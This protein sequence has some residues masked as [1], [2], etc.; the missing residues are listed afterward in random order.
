MF[1]R[2]KR[3][4]KPK[5][6]LPGPSCHLSRATESP[7]KLD[8]KDA[9]PQ[10]QSRFFSLPLEV[11]MQVYALLVCPR[12]KIDLLYE[13]RHRFKE[14][15]SWEQP[16]HPNILF[17]NKQIHDEAFDVLS[18]QAMLHLH[19]DQSL[20]CPFPEWPLRGFA[21]P[22]RVPNTEG[23]RLSPAIFRRFKRIKFT[24]FVASLHDD[25]IAA[26]DMYNYRPR[27]SYAP[28]EMRAGL[29]GLKEALG[30]LAVAQTHS[31]AT[32]ALGSELRDLLFL[33]L[34]LEWPSEMKKC[35]ADEFEMLW[36]K[37]GVWDLLGQVAKF[38]TI[39]FGGS[40]QREFGR[41]WL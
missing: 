12:G 31:T 18:G 22:M 3:Y 33:D 19:C 37:E 29:R 38:R 1:S 27:F 23:D 24:Y 6:S 39:H 8:T 7:E 9:T 5:S 16:I 14:Q 36:E 4:L 10:P 35:T 21:K 11:R 15:S 13:S 28:D 30:A 26:R 40:A 20:Y 32:A 17:L 2:I 34:E 41:Q 25:G